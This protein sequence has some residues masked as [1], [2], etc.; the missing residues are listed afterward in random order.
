MREVA[1]AFL[2]ARKRIRDIPIEK[3]IQTA[4]LP[5]YSRDTMLTIIGVYREAVMERLDQVQEEWTDGAV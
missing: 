3:A 4:G 2:E 5:T 1:S